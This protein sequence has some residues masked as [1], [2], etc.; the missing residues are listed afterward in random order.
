[1]DS[2]TVL[3]LLEMACTVSLLV[4]SRALVLAWA[5]L[6][7]ALSCE[8]QEDYHERLLGPLLSK[9]FWIGLAPALSQS[10]LFS[11]AGE[12]KLDCV[13]ASWLPV[14]DSWPFNMTSIMECITPPV[15]SQ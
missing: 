10:R 4:T 13:L 5:L 14:L 3:A 11:L 15:T 12:G 8:L 1:M 7:A 2:V 9:R 6:D